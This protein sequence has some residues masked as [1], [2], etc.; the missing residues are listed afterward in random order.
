MLKKIS[1]IT[2]LALLI[3]TMS[4]AQAYDPNQTAKIGPLSINLAFCEKIDKMSG[5]LNA[6]TNVQ[7]PVTGVPGITMGVLQ[8]SNVVLDFCDYLTRLKQMDTTDK[9]WATANY[10]NKLMGNKFDDQIGIMRSTWDIKDVFIDSSGKHRPLAKIATASNASKM[11]SYYKEVTDYYD[12]HLN[13]G[14]PVNVRNRAQMEGDLNRLNQIAYQKSIIVDMTNCPK[15]TTKN[16]KYA[17]VY[18]NDVVPQQAIADAKQENINFYSNAL[19]RMGIKLSN[20]EK[21]YTDYLRDLNTYETSVALYVITV[22]T[23]QA[24]SIT[25]VAVSP[26]P[27]DPKENR[28]KDQTTTVDKKYQTFQVENHNDEIDTFSKKYNTAWK[29]WTKSQSV[30]QTRGF[31]SGGLFG[32]SV[33]K[34]ED[35]FKDPNVFCNRSEISR[36]LAGSS[37]STL[38]KRTDEEYS[39]CVSESNTAISKAGGLFAFYVN[40]YAKEIQAYRVAQGKIWTIESYHL[41]YFRT[42]DGTVNADGFTQDKVSC[43]PID[44]LAKVNELGLQTEQINA[45]LNQMIVEQL[46]KKNQ[47]AELDRAQAQTA[48]EEEER[49][50]LIQQETQRRNSWDYS[51][52]KDYPENSGGIN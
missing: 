18:E 39:K 25:K 47:Q 11:N 24:G 44:N 36:K 3:L 7:W 32:D 49:R 42:V 2:P 33:A 52:Y 4:T 14:D 35:E 9:L 10:G 29:T 45:N 22:R 46:M 20:D 17:N 28:Y 27:K 21:K 23:E 51:K 8:R 48:K 5:I 43:A 41:G 50:M 30:Q 40:Q 31:L 6:F 19:R 34:I 16:D 37:P 12:K 1:I 26:A 13:T 38:Q 15:T